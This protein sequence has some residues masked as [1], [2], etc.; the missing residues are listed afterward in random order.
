MCVAGVFGLAFG[1]GFAFAV[2]SWLEFFEGRPDVLGSTAI[3]LGDGEARL[4]Q[5]DGDFLGIGLPQGADV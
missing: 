4:L 5:S 3:G 1:E 2:P